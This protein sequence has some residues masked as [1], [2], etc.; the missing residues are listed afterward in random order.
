LW[1]IGPISGHGLPLHV[2][3]ITLR[4]TILGGTPLDECSARRRDLYLTPRIIHRR[5]SLP[6]ARFGPT[7]P[8]SGRPQT[9]ALERAATWLG[10]CLICDQDMETMFQ[11]FSNTYTF[12]LTLTSSSYSS[13]VERVSVAPDHT[14]RHID[15]RYDS[16]ARVSGQSQRALPQR[17]QETDN[18]DPRRDESAIPASK[19]QR[20]HDLTTRSM[21]S[22]NTR[23]CW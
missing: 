21:G 13:S 14:H 9:H 2:F 4:H 7:I 12:F 19:W 18:H 8:A 6:K 11:Q 22:A 10:L 20:T 5:H 15:T 17:S 3:A 23:R 1:R 16:S